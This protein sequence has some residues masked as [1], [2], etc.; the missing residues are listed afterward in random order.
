MNSR[1]NKTGIY[2]PLPFFSAGNCDIVKLE[3]PDYDSSG[4][5]G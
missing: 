2:L 4:V 3:N 5:G 1:M